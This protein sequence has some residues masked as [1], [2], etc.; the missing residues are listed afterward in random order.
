LL[1][2]E[3]ATIF[4]QNYYSFSVVHLGSNTYD[5][6]AE[7]LEARVVWWD[8]ISKLKLDR[9]EN[10]RAKNTEPFGLRILAN[11]AFG[12]ESVTQIP[13]LPQLFGPLRRVIEE[14]ESQYGNMYSAPI[15]K[16]KANC[17]TSYTSQDQNMIAVGTDIGVY[18]TKLGST[19]IWLKVCASGD[20]RYNIS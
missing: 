11:A 13:V 12:S 14:F 8:S 6:A 18:I 2:L 15:N 5:L 16:V 4:T 19:E 9:A 20:S 17:A 7:T 10:L 1:A 3:H